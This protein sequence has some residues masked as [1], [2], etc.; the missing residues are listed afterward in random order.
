[1]LYYLKQEVEASGR[2]SRL[3]ETKTAH[4][5][6]TPKE[7]RQVIEN[8]HLFRG[9]RPDFIDEI[10]SSTTRKTVGADEILFQKGDQA[11]ALWGVLSGRIVIEVGSDDGKEMVL[12]AFGEGDVFGEVGVLDFGPRRVEARAVQKS[13]L[14]RLERNHFLRHLQTSPELCFR[15]F[16]LLCSHLRDTTENLEDTALH[17]LPNRL[18][19]RLTTL[20]V[21]SSAEDG[22]ILQISQSDLAGML[23]VH[24]QAVNRHLREWEKSGW[25]SIQRQRIEILEKKSLADLAAPGQ[26]LGQNVDHRIWSIDSLS[27]LAPVAFPTHSVP[28][29]MPE[30]PERRFAGILA[31]N[32]A[33]YAGMLMTDSANTIRRIRT[34]LAA[35]DKAIKD[36]G[37]RVIWSA[38][39]R[40][41]AEFPDG[42]TAV[43]AALEIQRNAGEAGSETAGQTDPIF[44]MGVHCGEVLASDGRLIGEPVNIAIRLTELFGS[45]GICFS[46]EVRDAL[47]DAGNLELQYLGNHDLKNVTTPV[48]VFSARSIPWLKRIALRTET[49]VPRRYRPMLTVGAVLLASAV[50]WQ[51]V[52]RFGVIKAPGPPAQSV[53]VLSFTLE[54][55]PEHAWLAD[56][57]AREIRAGL[58][59][60]PE[61]LVIGRKSSEYFDE[62][63]ATSQ[64]IGEIL[65]VAYVLQGTVGLTGEELKVSSRL[66][67][68]GT[69]TEIWNHDYQGSWQ[70]FNEFRA[71]IVRLAGKTLNEGAPA[72]QSVVLA[73]PITDNQEAHVLYLQARELINEQTKAS[74]IGA[75]TKLEKAL[76]LEP[77]FASAHVAI[78][79]TYLYLQGFSGYYM[80]HP[81]KES[82]DLARPHVEKALAIDANL[83][84]AHVVQGRLFKGE[85]EEKAESAFREAISLNP[86]LAKAHMWLG[87]MLGNQL[88]SWN[89]NLPH[90]EKAHEIEPLW[91]E[92]ATILVEFLQFIPDR[93][94]EALAII[95]KLKASH[96]DHPSVNQLE[97]FWLLHEGRP[98]EAVPLLEKNLTL[99]AS[100]Y[101]ARF[102]LNIAWFSLGEAQRALDAPDGQRQ[103]RFVLSPDREESLRQMIEI[104]DS[105]THSREL[106]A[107]IYIML[108][109]WQLTVDALG[110]ESSHPKIS[111]DAARLAKRYSPAM[112]LAV[113]YRALG[114]E[115]GYRKFAGIEKEALDIRSENGK[116]RNHEYSR[117]MARLYAMEGRSPEAMDELEQLITAGPNDPRELMHPAFDAM[118]D[119]PRFRELQGLQRQRVNEEREK[120]GLAPIP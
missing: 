82:D 104:G 119:L 112:S 10:A 58:A 99:D 26:N 47:E 68:T 64:E 98:S 80:V 69:G 5:K 62:W 102:E 20:A 40:T 101:W 18:A 100:S 113:A 93:R 97:A 77:E 120:L 36:H 38:G 7:I 41:L 56:G 6:A 106:S 25:I 63:N 39:D 8:S 22:T 81:L 109:E 16:S 94:D 105:P 65:R 21:E 70:Q 78:A 107:Y 103:W 114:D 32:C 13:E 35:T 28:E 12:D 51:A 43:D 24:R 86:N 111:L 115:A 4:S 29:T 31:V 59:A 92:A 60:M 19:K 110:P 45:G 71:D 44:R 66:V 108:H 15:V 37:G 46:G 54:G 33:G 118:R 116:I 2:K 67:E 9:L 34:G 89:E 72:S 76:A 88:R 117:T 57:L 27:G 50:I 1:M 90:L 87:I 96:P 52:Q 30:L 48:S 75:L 79:E 14:F 83:A 85:D 91:I 11:D 23:G 61:M 42:P 49:L 84:E 73:S 3:G 74:L 95:A 55:D 17:K 53:A